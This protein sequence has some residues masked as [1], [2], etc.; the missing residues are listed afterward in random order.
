MVPEL[1]SRDHIK[2]IVPVV[3]EALK[4]VNL[5][6]LN[7][8]GVTYGPGLIGSLLIGLSFAKSISYVLRIPFYGVNHI[9]GHIF[10]LF[11]EREIKTP[12]VALI[13]SGAHTELILVKRKGNYKLI[14][15]TLDDAAGESFDKVARLLG[16]T[17]P[18]G[19]VIEKLALSGNRQAIRFPRAEVAGYDFSFSGLK[20]AVLYYL[21]KCKAQNIK[22]KTAELSDIAASF[23]EAAIDSLVDKLMAAATSFKIPRVGVAGGVAAN[24]RLREKLKEVGEAKEIE[25]YFPKRE[26]CTDNGVMI[27]VCAQYY[28]SKGKTSEFSLKANPGASLV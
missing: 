16:F 2:N 11:I 24:S 20:T 4:P 25:V 3:E 27:A 26:F 12:F 23:Q 18:G 9:E 21:K 8:I 14:G 5:S 22:Y 28:L 1:A 13:V 6:E 15:T 19:P 17:Y 7:G 10:S